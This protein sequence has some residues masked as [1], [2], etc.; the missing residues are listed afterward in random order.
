[1]GS[2][3]LVTCVAR[4]E[5]EEGTAA[6]RA[7]TGACRNGGKRAGENPK[8]ILPRFFRRPSEALWKLCAGCR[9]SGVAC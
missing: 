5:S 1:M 6:A 7:P 8:G 4:E 3:R 9:H 2:R